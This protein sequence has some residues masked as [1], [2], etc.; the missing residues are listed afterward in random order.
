MGA[1]EANPDANGPPGG[2][3]TSIRRLPGSGL[4]AN[5][6]AAHN[7]D[8][9]GRF[10]ISMQPV[11]IN[12]NFEKNVRV[13]WSCTDGEFALLKLWQGIPQGRIGSRRNS[14]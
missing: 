2:G 8:A 12:A 14:S 5:P 11:I 1:F 10:S 9:H 4:H 6:G 13:D 7:T 3:S